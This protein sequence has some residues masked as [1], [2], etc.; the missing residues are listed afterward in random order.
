MRK[1]FTFELNKLKTATNSMSN[2]ESIIKLFMGMKYFRIKVSKYMKLLPIYKYSGVLLKMVPIEDFETSFQFLNEWAQYFLDVKDK[3]TKHA[4]A[5]LFVEILVP[6][7]AV[8][9]LIN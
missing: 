2:N 8:K 7:A 1:K 5:S 3:D 6:L 4:L 9:Y